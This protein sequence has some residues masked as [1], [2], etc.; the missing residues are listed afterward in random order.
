MTTHPS[1]VPAPEA[2]PSADPFELTAPVALAELRDALE[3]WITEARAASPVPNLGPYSDHTTAEG[4]M[5]A[6]FDSATI[7]DIAKDM[8]T[9]SPPMASRYA[10]A[11][12]HLKY[13]AEQLQHG[14]LL[15]QDPHHVYGP[16]TV[17]VL[18]RTHVAGAVA[19]V[20][21]AEMFLYDGPR[22]SAVATTTHCEGGRPGRPC[23]DG[24]EESHYVPRLERCEAA[25][26][27]YASPEIV[28]EAGRCVGP[29]DAVLIR[30][31]IMGPRRDP[32]D[33]RGARACVTHGTELL[34]ALEGATVYPGPSDTDEHPWGSGG[35]ATFVFK[36]AAALREDRD[37][38]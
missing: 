30:D 22:M 12:R 16:D 13:A 25:E 29:G 31:R 1:M 20:R 5:N 35:A 11:G 6:L 21:Q 19:Y 34:A 3:G 8:R 18:V 15:Q 26:A 23:S 36:S 38:R 14:H 9:M 32:E 10:R 28:T 24:R 27:L 7:F 33:Q 17:E 4:I 37:S 2:D